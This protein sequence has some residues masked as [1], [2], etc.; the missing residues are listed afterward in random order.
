MFKVKELLTK[1]YLLLLHIT[2]FIVYFNSY[3]VIRSQNLKGSNSYQNNEVASI[4][5]D[6]TMAVRAPQRFKG[7]CFGW[8]LG[9]WP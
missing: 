7:S 5:P 3:E 2:L 8:T 6:A 4:G 9:K 1:I